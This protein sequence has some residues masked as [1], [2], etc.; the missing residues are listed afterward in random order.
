[1]KADLEW[2]RTCLE[3]YVR[4]RMSPQ[5]FAALIGRDISNAYFILNGLGWKQVD[6]PEGFQYPWPERE[7]LGS[8]SRFR[9]RQ[10]EYIDVVGKFKKGEITELDAQK[11]LKVSPSAVRDILRRLEKKGLL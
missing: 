1:M 5:Q 2:R 9:R 11:Q 10:D 3:I 7:Y 4:E 6:R 8:R